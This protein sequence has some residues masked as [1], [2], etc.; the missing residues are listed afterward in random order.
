MAQ[1][2]SSPTPYL[3][4]MTCWGARGRIKPHLARVTDVRRE[5]LE[6]GAPLH[7]RQ[8]ALAVVA[9]NEAHAP[10]DPLSSQLYVTRAGIERVLDELRDRLARIGLAAREPTNQ[11]ERI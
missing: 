6:R 5:V 7:L 1:N 9:D 10:A 8:H 11:L 3:P 2:P 4:A